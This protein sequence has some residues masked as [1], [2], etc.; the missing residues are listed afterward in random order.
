MRPVGSRTLA[1]NASPGN[2][3]PAEWPG[4]LAMMI[5]AANFGGGGN[6]KL[7]VQ[8]LDGTWVAVTSSTLSANGT[9]TVNL[10]HC[11]VRAVITTA[12]AVYASL[13]HVPG[14]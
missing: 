8:A 10:P 11:Q 2:Q 12:T 9:L 3:S 5:V 4:G 7:E 14:N 6:V 13:H 1:S